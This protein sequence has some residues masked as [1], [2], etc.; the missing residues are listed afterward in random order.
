MISRISK[1][2][3]SFSKERI[4]FSLLIVVDF[5]SPFPKIA[6][7]LM[8]EHA[9]DLSVELEKH[10]SVFEKK[11]PSLFLLLRRK[12][13]PFLLLVVIEDELCGCHLC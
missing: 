11:F 6:V 8:D 12:H 1:S 3:V 9:L 13:S 4:C 2:E 5:V 10:L 7:I